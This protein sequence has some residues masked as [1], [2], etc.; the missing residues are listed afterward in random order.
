MK[1]IVLSVLAVLSLS[2]CYEDY[3]KDYDFNAVYFAKQI[4]TRTVVVGEGQKIQVGAVLAGVMENKSNREVHFE[5]DNSLV[6]PN[7]LASMKK[8]DTYIKQAVSDVSELK[9]L[10]SD[11]YTLSDDGTIVIPKGDHLGTIDVTVTDKFIQD[12]DAL[13][14][15]Y[16]LPLRIIS[17]DADSINSQKSTTV[18]GLHYEN[19]LFGNYYHGGVDQVKNAQGEVIETITYRTEIPQADKLIWKLSSVAPNA[20][21]T[22][23]ITNGTIA[24]KMKLTL[25]QDGSIIVGAVEG[26]GVEVKS[27]GESFFNQAKLLQDRQIFLKYQFVDKEGN[28]HHATDTLSFRNRIRDGVNEWKDENPEHYK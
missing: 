8:G 12:A 21:V 27:D 25:N 6:T 17:A 24:G 4:N 3:I 9:A 19:T 18:I 7:V 16:V 10:P 11:Y 2:S 13:K 5:I 28:S 1:K 23:Q 14:A 15:T 22:N 20:L 26:S